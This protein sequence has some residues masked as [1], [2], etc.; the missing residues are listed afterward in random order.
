MSKIELS[1]QELKLLSK[2]LRYSIFPSKFND[3]EIQAQFEGLFSQAAN[4]MNPSQK[5]EFKACLINCYSLF[6]SS[7][8]FYKNTDYYFSKCDRETIWGLKKKCDLKEVLLIKADKGNTVVLI[9]KAK[10]IE[11]MNEILSDESKFE[12]VEND[13]KLDRQAKFQFFFLILRKPLVTK[14]MMICITRVLI[15]LYCMAYL[16][17]TN[18]VFQ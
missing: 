4:Y 10:Y 6:L 9:D 17:Y 2:G 14:N 11:C 13:D 12:K 15:Y 3:K 16:K 1:E 8:K 7:F 5:I 18:M